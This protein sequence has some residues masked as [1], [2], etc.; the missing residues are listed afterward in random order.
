V[1]LFAALFANVLSLSRGTL[2]MT[3]MAFAATLLVSCV[4]R[5]S[6][7]KIIIVAAGGVAAG[8]VLLKEHAAIMDR[9]QNAP[10]ES[11]EARVLFNQAAAAML[12]DHP[13]GVGLN[14]FSHS[15]DLAGYADRL[16]IGLQD[17]AGLAHHV[18]WLTAAE[19]GIVGIATFLLM[20]AVP[21]WVTVAGAVRLR[22][23]GRGHLLLGA[24]VGMIAM[25]VHG[26][27]EWVSR[28]TPVSYL[29]WIVAG[30][31]YGLTRRPSRLGMAA[32][33]RSGNEAREPADSSAIPSGTLPALEV[34]SC[35]P[36]FFSAALSWLCQCWAAAPIFPRLPVLRRTIRRSC[37]P[38]FPRLRGSR[39]IPARRSH[40]CP[41]T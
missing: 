25:H 37:R 16:G 14:Q 24:A 17:R 10:V 31:A 23:T 32:V 8:L 7:R 18:F 2:A 6:S 33:S 41:A 40:F 15:L 3:A 38:R 4:Q 26:T 19:T 5:F 22:G 35:G 28:Q 39:S 1:A 12:R 13:F 11:E 30:L 36:H 20:L 9:F 21:L 29:F 27:A 34:R